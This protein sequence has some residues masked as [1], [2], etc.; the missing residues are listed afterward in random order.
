MALDVLAEKSG[1]GAKELIVN[2]KDHLEPYYDIERPPAEVTIAGRTF[3]RFDYN[4]LLSHRFFPD[5]YA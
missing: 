3:T 2:R 1:A 5:A 4:A